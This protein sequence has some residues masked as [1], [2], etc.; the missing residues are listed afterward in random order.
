MEFRPIIT[1]RALLE[2]LPLSPEGSESIERSRT[3]I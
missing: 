2:K 3:I 1:P